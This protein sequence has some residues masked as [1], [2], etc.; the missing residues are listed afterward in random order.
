MK[1]KIPA[2][3]VTGF[4]GAGKTTFLNEV[5]RE[6]QHLKM[7][8][9]ENEFGQQSIDQDLIVGMQSE[10]VFDLSNG[11]ICCSISNEFS[12][13]LLELASKAGDIDFLLVETT[14]IA[15]LANVIKPF[16][17]DRE[18]KEQYTLAGSVCLV[19]AANFDQQ[20][21]EREQQ[22]QVILSDLLII[23]KAELVSEEELKA[24]EK[25]L[26]AWNGTAKIIHSSYGKVANFRLE[27]FSE[28]VQGKLEKKMAE[29]VMFRLIKSKKYTTFTHEFPGTISISRFKYWFDYFAAI[30]QREI[31]RI[32]GI[33]FSKDSPN[34]VV[35]QSVGGA[36]SYSEG[37]LIVPGETPN[38]RLVFIGKEIDFERIGY[39]LDR[40]LTKD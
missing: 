3:L 13:T 5:I 15:D 23:N 34:K 39:E 11:C 24:I 19:D 28:S 2:V 33:L 27:A 6:H 12:L 9:V 30:N 22:M 16:Y 32:K 25:K 4:L 29:P 26:T 36:T 7:A 14:G 38:N 37:S 20:M 35:V 1:R 10:N 18:L 8:L 17:E 21:S 31:Y 40:Y